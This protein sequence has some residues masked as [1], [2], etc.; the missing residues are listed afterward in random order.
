M[1]SLCLHYDLQYHNLQYDPLL[2]ALHYHPA[3]LC[4]QFTLTGHL[5]CVLSQLNFSASNCSS[6]EA[7][8][9]HATQLES[10]APSKE[11]EDVCTLDV[12]TAIPRLE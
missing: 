4:L 9:T 5:N 6:P 3:A 1:I 10:Q 7:W 2:P 11:A 8:N 12:C